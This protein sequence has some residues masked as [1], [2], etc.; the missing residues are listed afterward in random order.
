MCEA[1]HFNEDGPRHIPALAAEAETPALQQLLQPSPGHAVAL[2]PRPH[3]ARTASGGDPQRGHKDPGG[4]SPRTGAW[5]AVAGEGGCG[6]GRLWAP[7]GIPQRLL[8]PQPPGAE[9]AEAGGRPPRPRPPPP[10]PPFLE[11]RSLELASLA[12]AGGLRAR[13]VPGRLAPASFV[14]CHRAENR[15]SGERVPSGFRR[16]LMVHTRLA[17]TLQSVPFNFNSI[18]SFGRDMELEHFDERDKAQRYSRGSRVNGLPSPTHSAHCSFYRTRTLQTLSSEKKAKKVRFYR[19]GDRYFKGIVYAISP[20]RFRSFEAL[21]ADLTRTLSDNV[22]LP[23]GVRT[24]YTIDGLKKISSLDQLVEGESYVCGSIEPFKKLEYTKNVNPNWSVNVKTTSASRAVSSLATAKGGPSE[25]REN[26]D[27][28]RP[29][30][31]TI[32]RSGVKPRKA[33]R[34]LLNKKTAHSF[35]QVLTDITDAIKLDS[36]VVKRL[37]TLD[38]KQVSERSRS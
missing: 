24:I 21:L 1:P 2:Q 25:V 37:Y 22:N 14:W 4:I 33:V 12:P 28:I 38:G 17:A 31:V 23:Q 13:A 18:M 32:I 19:N 30:L 6:V 10:R 8:L 11:R 27:F 20:D 29:K 7:P 16:V 34:I 35:E 5:F 3:P 26:K 9:G 36:G 15:E